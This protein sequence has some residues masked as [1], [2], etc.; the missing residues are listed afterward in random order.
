MSYDSW[1]DTL[2][3]IRNVQSKLLK[4]VEDLTERALEH[5]KSKLE[6]PEKEIYDKYSPAL[7]TVEYNSKEYKAILKEMKVGIDHHYS[8]NRHHPQFFPDSINAMNLIDLIEMLVDWKAA[9]ER[10]T[11]KPIDIFQ[12]IEINSDDE[13]FKIDPQLKQILLNTATYLWYE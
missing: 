2:E 3:H 5:D 9:G 12:S 7:R 13:H 10:H 4:V 6:S 8:V 11:E 1:K